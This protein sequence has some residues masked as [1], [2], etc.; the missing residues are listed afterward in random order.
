MRSGKDSNIVNSNYLYLSHLGQK[1]SVPS[2]LIFSP[3]VVFIIKHFVHIR[4]PSP[5]ISVPQIQHF[6]KLTNFIQML[7]SACLATQFRT[8]DKEK[9]RMESKVFF[10]SIVCFGNQCCRLN[11]EFSSLLV[12]SYSSIH[13][14]LTGKPK[15]EQLLRQVYLFFRYFS[16]LLFRV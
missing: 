10:R 13:R 8:H 9:L 15:N 3:T 16:N 12:R 14:T 11:S 2:G 4:G 5:G 1:V 7:H 6:L